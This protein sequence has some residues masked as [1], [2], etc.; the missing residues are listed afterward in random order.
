MYLLNC[1]V[2]PNCQDCGEHTFRICTSEYAAQ[3]TLSEICKQLLRVN[4]N[5]LTLQKYKHNCRSR[6]EINVA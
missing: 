4:I 3:R 6:I 5:A 2:T 1:A